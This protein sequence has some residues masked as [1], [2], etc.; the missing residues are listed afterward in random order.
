MRILVVDDH[1]DSAELIERFICQKLPV[2]EVTLASNGANASQL[3]YSDPIFD[4]IVSDLEMPYMDGLELLQ[5]SREICP[6][7][8]FILVSG[9]ISKAAKEEAIAMGAFAVLEKPIDLPRFE[10]LI[11]GI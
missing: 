3:L 10:Q 4:L 1:Q 11:K 9:H 7:T 2:A 6:E 8:P 5:E